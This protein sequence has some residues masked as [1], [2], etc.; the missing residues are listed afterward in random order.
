MFG[1]EFTNEEKAFQDDLNFFC[2]YRAKN[3]KMAGNRKYELDHIMFYACTR[4]WDGR[5]I[6]DINWMLKVDFRKWGLL[7]WG[8][9]GKVAYDSW[10]TS[11]LNPD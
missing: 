2:E 8:L 6:E 1:G 11:K 4:E 5:K 3:K 7:G 9:S 10:E